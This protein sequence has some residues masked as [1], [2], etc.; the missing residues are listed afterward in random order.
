MRRII[1]MCIWRKKSNSFKDSF[2][3]RALIQR[4][5]LEGYKRHF[6][7]EPWRLGGWLWMIDDLLTMWTMPL[8]SILASPASIIWVR[9]LEAA[10]SL[11]PSYVI[12]YICRSSSMIFSVLR[13][14]YSSLCFCSSLSAVICAFDLRLLEPT[15]SRLEPVPFWIYTQEE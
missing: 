13:L 6:Y 7:F 1:N 8:S 12:Y 5:Y 15:R 3:N 9:I 4:N 10:L 11:S 2:R 14:S